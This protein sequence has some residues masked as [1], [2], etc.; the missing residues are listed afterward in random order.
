MKK[1][2]VTDVDPV[3]VNPGLRIL[4]GELGTTD[5]A[6]NRYDV[7]PGGNISGGYHAHHDQEEVFYVE[8][9]VA[10]FETDTGD[11]DV[12]AGELLRFG[13]G[14]F[15]HGYNASDE[16]AVVIALGAPPQSDEVESV[17]ECP[18]CGD[19]FH[20]HRTSFMGKITDPDDPAR[21]VECPECGAETIRIGR[22]D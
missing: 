8:S 14:E 18:A 4:T 7:D 3:P 13:P 22:P 17:R 20:H 11:V 9:G 10:R 16:P 1:I 5:V 2:T 15:H 19:R 21:R 12:E 6:I